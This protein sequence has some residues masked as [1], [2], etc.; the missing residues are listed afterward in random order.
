[1][2]GTLLCYSLMNLNLRL[3]LASLLVVSCAQAQNRSSSSHRAARAE[4]PAI[5]R[6]CIRAHMEFLAS[7][8][9]RGRGSATP[10]ELV[11]ATYIASELRQ[12]G[13]KPAGDNGDFLQRVPLIQRKFSAPSQLLF[14]D[15]GEEVA[16]KH[17]LEM[18]VLHAGT[19]DVS[20]ALQII[21]ADHPVPV[22]KGA[23]VFLTSKSGK[24]PGRDEPEKMISGGAAAVLIPAS[25]YL[26]S[27]WQDE[28]E[29]R[30]FHTVELADASGTRPADHS[31]IIMLNDEAAKRLASVPD[32]TAMRLSVSED[33]PGKEPTWNVLGEVKGADS[34]QKDAAL[35]LSAH[36]DHLGVGEAVNGD[37]IYN[38]ADDDAS[39]VAAVLE[40]ARVLGKGPR[41]GR[42]VIF[43]LF[44]S[45]ELGDLGSTY[46]VD[47]SP[48]PLAEIAADLEF[49]MIGRPDPAVEENQLWLTGW[50]RSDLGPTLAAHG[51]NLVADPHPD[52][53]FFSRSDN[54][55]L[56]KKGVVAQTVSSFGLHP[57]Y[58][59]PS[60]EL[61]EIDFDH[62]DGA[63]GSMLRPIEW[64][65]NSDFHPQWKPGGQP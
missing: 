5:C 44:G 58:H 21:D 1:M 27:H 37:S 28:A 14:K 31:N 53:N 17:G 39:G 16:W 42:D 10:D 9:L 56:A 59:Q 8:A 4:K 50:N 32:G 6:D 38:G 26:R 65:V 64:L 43:A 12:Y 36:L 30:F 60:D 41:P 51:A 55:A 52:Q 48:V 11:A 2:A 23:F 61:S 46:F 29:R 49:E 25:D 45:E 47:H 34:K 19:N 13:I 20:G 18:L 54:Y 15:A 24:K 33:Q 62:M 57:D 63:I 3:V 22:Q 7:D 40:L 35:L